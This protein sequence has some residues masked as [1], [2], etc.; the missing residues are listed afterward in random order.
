MSRRSMTENEIARMCLMQVTYRDCISRPLPGG[1]R[2]S[3][4]P[5]LIKSPVHVVRYE[6]NC[7]PPPSMQVAAAGTRIRMSPAHIV[8]SD[9]EL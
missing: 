8:H 9:S 7:W 6:M 4:R 2:G 3:P 1:S 5:L